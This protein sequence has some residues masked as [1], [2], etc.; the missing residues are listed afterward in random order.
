M[1]FEKKVQVNL[2]NGIYQTSNQNGVNN[3]NNAEAASVQKTGSTVAANSV[4]D[5]EYIDINIDETNETTTAQNSNSKDENVDENEVL[6]KQLEAEIAKLE[7][8]YSASQKGKGIA[9][10]V[11]GFFSSCWNGITGKGF[12]DGARVELDKKIALLEAA[13]SDPTKLAEAYKEIMGCDLTDEVRESAIEAQKVADSLSIEEK[14]EIIATLKE[15]AASLSQLMEETKDD[16]GWFSKAMGGLNNVLG[17]GTN[18]IKADAK[19]AEFI[20]QVNSLDANDPDFAAKYQALTGEALSLEGIEELS[21]GVSKV[22]NSS[23]AEAIIDYEETQAAAKEIGSGIVVG[24]VVAACVIAAP[25]TGGASIAL[26]AAVGGATTV[27]INATDTIGTSKKYSLEQ[28]LLDFG[29]GAINGAVTAMTLGGAGLAGKGFSALKGAGSSAAKQS[30]KEMVS[31]G[32][33]NTAKSAFKGFG[34]SAMRGAKIA[35]FSSTSNYLLSTVGTNAIYEATGNY[36]KSETP[37]NIVQNE[38]GTYSVYYELKDATTGDV[39]SYEIETVDTLSQDQEGNL[40]KGNVLNVSRSN[41]FNLKDLAKQTAISAGTAALG[42]G[43]GKVTNNIINPYATSITNSVVV[44]NTAEIASDMTLSLGADYLIASAQAGKFIDKDE[45]FSWDRILGEGRNQIRGLLIGIAS[46]KV[47]GVDTVSVDAVRAGFDGKTSVNMGDIPV[48]TGIDADIPVKAGTELPAIKLDGAELPETQKEVLITAGK[49]ILEENNPAKAGELLS[50]FG[51]SKDEISVFFEDS[52]AAKQEANLSTFKPVQDTSGD[53]P[54]AT[55]ELSGKAVSDSPVENTAQSDEVKSKRVAELLEKGIDEYSAEGITKL[56]DAQY[57]KAIGLLDRGIDAQNAKGIAE[58]DDAQYQKAVGLLDRGIDAQVAKDIAVLDNAR[59]QKAIE[60][61]DRGID[62]YNTKNIANLDDIQYQKAV[63]LLNKNIDPYTASELAN[64]DGTQYQKAVYLLD[65]GVESYLVKGIAELDD[66]QFQKTIGL[67]DKGISA[68]YAKYIANLDEAQYQKAVGLTGKGIPEHSIK[69][70]AELDDAQYAK[71]IELLDKKVDEY[72]IKEIAGLD[73]VQYQKA[74]KLLDNNVKGYNVKGFLEL[75]DAQYTKAIDLLGKSIDESSAKRMACFDDARY[76]KVV[77]LVDRGI[78]SNIAEEISG[79]DDVKYQK[80]MD[81]LSKNINAQSAKDIA[82]LDD[83]K[84]Q[85]AIGLLNKNVG[86]HFAY[87]LAS[88]DDVKYQRVIDLR[89]KGMDIN[90]ASSIGCLDDVKYQ[91]VIDLINKGMDKF[92]AS[93]IGCLDDAQYHKATELLDKGVD[94]VNAKDLS[95]LSDTQFQKAVKF[96]DEGID[97]RYIRSLVQ[98]EVDYTTMKSYVAKGLEPNDALFLM[99]GYKATDAQIDKIAGLLKQG[100]RMNSAIKATFCENDI[101]RRTD[102]IDLSGANNKIK[103]TLPLDINDPRY[104]NPTEIAEYLSAKIE[105]Q[106]GVITADDISDIASRLSKETGMSEDEIYG[107]MGRI[108][109]F[110]S[111]SQLNVL[112]EALRQNGVSA[113]YSGSGVSANTALRYV[114]H[115]K[116][117]FGLVEHGNTQ[118]FVLDEVGVKYLESLDGITRE[119][120]IAEVKNGKIVLVNLDGTNLRIGDNYYSNTILDG[121][122]NIESLTRGVIKE[123]QSGKS[124]DEVVNGDLSAKVAAILGLDENTIINI[125]TGNNEANADAVAAQIRP[126]YPT[127]KEIEIIIDE[128]I[129]TAL[130]KGEDP[131]QAKAVLAKYLDHMLDVNSSEKL[132]TT[133]QSKYTE[134]QSKVKEMG[135]TMDDV[136][137]V[138]ATKGKSFELVDYMFMKINGIDSSRFIYSNGLNTPFPKDSVMVVLDDVVGGGATMLGQE[139]KYYQ[140]IDTT[141][142]ILF[143]PITCSANGKTN[144]TE[145]IDEFKRIGTDYLLVDDKVFDIKAFSDKLSRDDRTLLYKLLG[146][147]GVGSTYLC[148][149][150]PYM[151]PDNNSGFSGLFTAF[152]LNNPTSS[153]SLGCNKIY[154]KIKDIIKNNSPGT[155]NGI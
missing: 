8:E 57:Q 142:N 88:L 33:K 110:A 45:F 40:I 4:D 108:T 49:L 73:D 143:S 62:P 29:G 51:M 126:N 124:I 20:K 37:A 6:I 127:A 122:Q 79:F 76:Q 28:G 84:Y 65:K 95:D 24:I 25:F 32:F 100:V 137:F 42:A 133:L 87:S 148:T 141:N 112:G 16:Q 48:K 139:F 155:I 50:T 115:N 119:N 36:A 35:T 86:E 135:K 138:Y 144:I 19:I 39:I 111:Y 103:E 9:G 18:S 61:L 134:I 147:Q 3:V 55:A 64:L 145:K 131:A 31:G 47:N 59:Y 68:S 104:Q 56:D 114:Q 81:L 91:R 7:S 99:R 82:S 129:K 78:S 22:G 74:I 92:A 5:S 67:L 106:M 151:S 66:V 125:K 52:I 90:S 11:G 109:Q 85:K 23:A 113:F 43:I 107:V 27:L 128:Y 30:A 71:V 146:S 13:K 44:G 118:A 89:D 116:G 69:E 63:E 15:Q 152:F 46:S 80:A 14:E 70:Y 60:L 149:A 98:D 75:D 12:K 96:L 72:S 102:G 93:N 21:Q 101:I 153:K 77:E 105:N 41:D 53:T 150:F 94:L 2:N 97:A 130:P 123:I 154:E 117:Q 26:G 10:S 34:Q 132:S 83:A 54:K 38:D 121:S 17:F 1:S 120:F 136:Y 58:L 140:A